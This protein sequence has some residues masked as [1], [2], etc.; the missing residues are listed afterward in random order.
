[1][2]NLNER[3]QLVRKVLC[4]TILFVITISIPLP[5]FSL[6]EKKKNKQAESDTIQ[7]KDPVYHVDSVDIKPMFMNKEDGNLLFVAR[8]LTYPPK[9]IEERVQGQVVCAFIITKDGVL[10]EPFV[11]KSVHKDLDKEALRVIKR[12]KKWTPGILNGDS[13][14]VMYVM[15]LNFRLGPTTIITRPNLK[16]M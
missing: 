6:A 3:N 4:L 15:P 13:V 2:K 10:T 11:L 14:N 16:T 5:A 1:M 12:M 9:L 7:F 8:N